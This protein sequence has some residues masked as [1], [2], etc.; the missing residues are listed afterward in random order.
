MTHGGA[1]VTFADGGHQCWGP[2]WAVR[3][4]VVTIDKPL[5]SF[6]LGGDA[7][8]AVA[9]SGSVYCWGATYYGTVGRDPQTAGEVAMAG[10]VGGIDDAVSVVV[11][12]LTACAVRRDQTVACWGY[13]VDDPTTDDDELAWGEFGSWRPVAVEGIDDA[14]AVSA[15][16][17]HYC[18]ITASR[19]PLCWTWLPGARADL[20]PRD[21]W[22][23]EMQ[24]VDL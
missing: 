3:P 6:G 17:L 16:A 8:C 22:F 21:R 15:G 7:S 11:G 13:G 24:Q 18:A 10:L 4:D 19:G 20:L 5:R 2:A 1:C 12:S 14:L 9:V 23:M